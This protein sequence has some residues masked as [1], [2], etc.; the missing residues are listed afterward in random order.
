MTVPGGAA[1]PAAPPPSR[2]AVGTSGWSY[3]AWRSGF[4]AGVPRRAWLAHCAAHFTGVEINASFYRLPKPGT[5]AAWRAATPDG[6]TFAAK[7]HRL[8]THLRRLR[9][10]DDGVAAARTALAPLGD[11]LGAVLWQ[12]PAI[13]ERDLERLTP[14][15]TALAVWPEVRHVVEFR[16]VSWFDDAVAT[17]LESH[18]VGICQS[19]APRWPLWDAVTAGLV[20]ARLH[21]H[22]RL[23]TSRYGPD[24]LQPWAERIRR[25]LAKG[26]DVYVF[27][28]NDAEGA[29]PADAAALLD[30]L[31]R[32]RNQESR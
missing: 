8:V 2:L 5:V 23:Y 6:F 9:Q 19:D 28:D 24:G 30:L 10:A 22:E 7:G 27:F 11:R 20:Y 1:G 31:G 18:G 12:L 13:L 3:P 21:G 15:L 4:Y 29:A 16:H 14:F 25:W 26:L 17:A 32:G